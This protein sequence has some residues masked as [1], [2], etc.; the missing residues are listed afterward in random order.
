MPAP[1][2]TVLAAG[3]LLLVVACGESSDDSSPASSPTTVATSQVIATDPAT[4]APPVTAPP[5]TAAPTMAEAPATDAPPTTQAPPATVAGAAVTI[6]SVCDLLTADDLRNNPFFLD[7]P[8]AEGNDYGA[9]FMECIWTGDFEQHEVRVSVLPKE[10][11]DEDFA[12]AVPFDLRGE[13]IGGGEL[14]ED[15]MGIGRVGRG[16]TA[17]YTVGDQAI[18]VAV[19]TGEDGTFAAD[20]VFAVELAGLI[21]TRI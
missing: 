21:L 14:F 2:S 5:V 6:T 16:T 13:D 12:A 19:R 11:Y 20:R 8:V 15:L 7:E 9:G 1:R 17:V 18:M 10:S 4:T 3:C